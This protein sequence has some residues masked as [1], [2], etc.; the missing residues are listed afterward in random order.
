MHKMSILILSIFTVSVSADDRCLIVNGFNLCEDAK[1]IANNTK[2][3]IG[4]KMPGSEYILKSVMHENMTVISVYESIYTKEE[5]T[6]NITKS[7]QHDEKSSATI[8]KSFNKT[9]E[10]S[11]ERL[12]KIYSADVFVKDGGAFKISYAYKNGEVFH[13]VLAEKNNCREINI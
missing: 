10:K 4:I 3:D 7:M 6:R 1:T 9:L 11:T 8:T 5:I 12:C 2:T 13:T